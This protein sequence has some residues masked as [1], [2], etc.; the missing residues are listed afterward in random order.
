MEQLAAWIFW[1]TAA[2]VMIPSRAYADR[3]FEVLDGL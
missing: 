2:W 1:F 3:L